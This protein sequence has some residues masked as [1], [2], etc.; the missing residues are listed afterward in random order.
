MRQRHIT[1]QHQPYNINLGEE[2]N[3]EGLSWSMGRL[4]RI[5][6][7]RR[8]SGSLNQSRQKLN[9]AMVINIDQTLSRPAGTL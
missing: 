1:S 7:L 3:V 2:N 9:L 6:P 4:F 5:Y 8:P